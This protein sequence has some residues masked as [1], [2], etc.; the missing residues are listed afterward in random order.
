MTS[1]G[2]ARGKGDAPC[3]E[4]NGAGSRQVDRP[5]LRRIPALFEESAVFPGT[6]GEVCPGIP[7]HGEQARGGNRA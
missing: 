4:E 7:V 6:I 2:T 3:V 1:G 5:G